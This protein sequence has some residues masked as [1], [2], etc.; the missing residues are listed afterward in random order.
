LR[1]IPKL[2]RNPYK[3]KTRNRKRKTVYC[4]YSES[5]RRLKNNNPI[6]MHLYKSARELDRAKICS[7]KYVKKN[8]EK[9]KI[10]EAIT[11]KWKV[12]YVDREEIIQIIIKK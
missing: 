1:F 12:Y 5:K 11:T 6:N 9:W 4:E 3:K 10:I 8:I 2:E 7:A